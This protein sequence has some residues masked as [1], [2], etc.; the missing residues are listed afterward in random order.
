MRRGPRR[1]RVGPVVN[2]GE[3][4]LDAPGDSLFFF[5]DTSISAPVTAPSGTTLK[6]LCAIHPWMQG[7]IVVE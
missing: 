4:G 2:A 5:D 6:Y 7:T 3:P 1:T